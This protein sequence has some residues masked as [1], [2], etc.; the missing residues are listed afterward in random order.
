VVLLSFCHTHTGSNTLYSQYTPIFSPL[1]QQQREQGVHHLANC[2]CETKR[3]CGIK[4]K[5][6]QLFLSFLNLNLWNLNLN[7]CVSV[8]L[9][10]IGLTVIQLGLG[11]VR[12]LSF[13]NQQPQCSVLGVLAIGYKT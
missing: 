7:E 8:Y 11:L 9:L 5:T 13:H 6:K 3:R 12:L 2:K 1:T 10:A 4:H